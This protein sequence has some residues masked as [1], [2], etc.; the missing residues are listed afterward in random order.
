MLYEYEC[1]C[2]AVHEKVFKV[3]NFP[4]TIKCE[5]GGM[6]R[7]IISLGAIRT[8][9]DVG[10]MESASKN[11]VKHG[12]RPVTTRTE[13]RNYLKNNNLTAIG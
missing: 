8:D 7:K 12:E 5:C 10:W 4:N 2:G 11:L 1:K 13:Y 6:A 3:T 9:G